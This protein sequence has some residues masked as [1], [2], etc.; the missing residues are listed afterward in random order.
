MLNTKI[1][2]IFRNGRTWLLEVR[3]RIT[4][5][6]AGRSRQVVAMATLAGVALIGLVAATLD[7]TPKPAT[8]AVAVETQ[9]DQAADRAN[10][11]V[12]DPQ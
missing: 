10:R 4:N 1:D 8:S 7:T 9:R 3:D 2:D 12:R 6:L 11:S 5:G